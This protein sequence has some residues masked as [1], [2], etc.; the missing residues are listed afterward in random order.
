MKY[1]IMMTS[2]GTIYIPQLMMIGS[3]TEVILS[4]LLQQFEMPY[5]WY[6]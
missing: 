4:L 3:G 2:D 1:A 6:S 5:C